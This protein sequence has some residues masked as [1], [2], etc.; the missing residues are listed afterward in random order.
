MP[1]QRGADQAERCAQIDIQHRLPVLVLHAHRQHV[2]GEA[3]IVDQDVQRPGL[4]LGLGDQRIGRRR[5]AQVGGADMGALAE[6]RGERVER[7]LA[8]AGQHDHGTLRMECPRDRRPNPAGSPG[9]QRSPAIQTKHQ[10]SPPLRKSFLVLFSKKEPLASC[11]FKA[12]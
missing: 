2:A 5:I 10:R 12:P 3:G 11:W 6:F 4:R 1:L 8:G 9:N 7:P